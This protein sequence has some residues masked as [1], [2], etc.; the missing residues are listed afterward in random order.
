[1]LFSF[2]ALLM[3]GGCSMKR[4]VVNSTALIMDDV[5]EAFFEEEDLEFARESA[6]ANLKL[7]DGLIKG[8]GYKNDGLLIKGAKLYAMYAMGFLED[9]ALD[10]RAD[11]ENLR[12]ASVFYDRARDYG[13]EVLSRNADFKR[14][15]AGTLDEF[16]AVLP[17]FGKNDVEALF[18]TGFAWGEY[19]NLNRNSIAAIADLPKVKALIDRVVELDGSYFYGIPHLFR[20]VYYS[21]PPMF[22]GD[23]E[24]ALAEYERINGISGGKF[25]LAHFFMAKYYA[26]RVQDEALFDEL[27]KRTEAVADDAIKEKLFTLAAKKKAAL[28]AQKKKDLF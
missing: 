16:K 23:Y 27:L 6:P 5:I 20:I 14:A 2:A 12:R 18:W 25:A 26:V 1:M 22:G 10:R 21:M 19:I 7:L 3:F 17:A 8:S 4:M 24:K 9:A 13:L 11:R 28:L 15:V